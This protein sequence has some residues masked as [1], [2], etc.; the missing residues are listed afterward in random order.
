MGFF[1]RR[2]TISRSIYR[3]L[4]FLTV[5][6][7]ALSL[8]YIFSNTNEAQAMALGDSNVST[9]FSNGQLDGPVLFNLILVI[10]VDIGV[11][12]WMGAQLWQTLVLQSTDPADQEQ[13]TYYKQ[14]IQRFERNFSLPTLLLILLANLG[15]L[16][17]QTP[18][19][20][21]SSNGRVD[22]FWIMREVVIL[23]AIAFGVYTFLVRQRPKF[24]NSIIPLANLLLGLLLLMAL[25]LSGH[26]AATSK[27]LLVY[28]IL[29]DWLHL[30]GAALWIGGMMYIAIICL[31][32]LKHSSLQENAH[33]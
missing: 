26:A 12:F 4:F 6:S 10:L 22:T 30:V 7:L 25:S 11:V 5:L 15:I 28:S 20:G 33:L 8:L 19:A 16:M 31:P 14:V 27:N 17:G 2:Y 13:A 23:L 24:I 32:I 21:L 9:G 29:V 1:Q 18:L 3:K